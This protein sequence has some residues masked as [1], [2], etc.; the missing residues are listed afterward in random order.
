MILPNTANM[1]IPI[2]FF[3]Y[4]QEGLGIASGISCVVILLHFT[5]GVF[6][7][8]KK[9]SLDVVIKSP[10]VYAII[11]SVI[12]FTNYKCK[13]LHKKVKTMQFFYSC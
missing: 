5:V 7:A 10:P 11:I 12:F 6:L 1:G 8:K 9:F 13:I 2:C 4:G 3:A